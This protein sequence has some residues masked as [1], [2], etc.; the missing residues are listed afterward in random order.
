MVSIKTFDTT[1]NKEII[2]YLE[3]EFGK[4][5]KE[6]V[7]VKCKGGSRENLLIG[8][9]TSLDS[10]C[11]RP[12]VLAGHIDTVTADESAYVTDPYD[13]VLNGNKMYGLGTI[14][15][16]SFFATILNNVELLKSMSVP[17]V[18]AITGDEETAL[19]GVESIVDVMKNRSIVPFFTIVGEP[20]NMKICTV[21]KSCYEYSVKIQGK[22]C[23]SSMPQ[24]GV[25]AN[26]IACRIALYIEKLC[27][28]YTGTTLTAN[29][30]K[31]GEK[32]NIVSNSAQLSF[33]IRSDNMADYNKIIRQI[34]AFAKR[35]ERRY[36]GSSIII[37]EKLSIPPL[38]NRN[39]KLINDVCDKFCLEQTEFMGGCEAGYFQSL[40]GDAIVFGVGDLSLA[41][42]PNEYVVVSEFEKYNTILIKMLQF[43]ENGKR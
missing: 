11:V 29:I 2:D 9:N 30:I 34:K 22:S 36:L 31:G 17:V 3:N 14:D 27:T 19:K 18:V 25:N 43:V 5:A 8:L 28:K 24:N 7:R 35:L 33:D 16:K 40:G 41:H 32:V 38:E 42:K 1:Q 12:V 6:M 10:S 13:G 39:S 37:E 4:Y 20:T 15:M 26:Y 21:S 23:H